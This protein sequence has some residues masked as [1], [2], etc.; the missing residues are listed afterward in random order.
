MYKRQGQGDAVAVSAKTGQGLDRLLARLEV[1]AGAATDAGGGGALMTRARHRVE[2][3]AARDALVRFR[4]VPA[5]P[6]LKAEE[7]RIAARHLGRLT[8]RIDI[9][10]V[11]G[12][13]FAEFC[14]GK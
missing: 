2:L 10:D 8:G 12:E 14:I 6:E 7:L 5:A 13:V 3:E 4:D 1:E 11:L 9:E